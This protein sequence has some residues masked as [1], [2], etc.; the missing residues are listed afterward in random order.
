MTGRYL[1]VVATVAICCSAAPAWADQ[2]SAPPQTKRAHS[3]CPHGRS[4]AAKSVNQAPPRSAPI[5]V[6]AG[7]LPLFNVRR[8][9][10][11]LLP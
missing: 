4:E 11:D 2:R 7:S 5:Q 3:A 10:P 6:S 1:L 8:F 9:A